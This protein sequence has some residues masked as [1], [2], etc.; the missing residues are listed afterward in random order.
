[1]LFIACRLFFSNLYLFFDVFNSNRPNE[2]PDMKPPV[3]SF[4]LSVFRL[5]FSTVH[6]TVFVTPNITKIGTVFSKHET[7]NLLIGVFCANI[8]V[9]LEDIFPS[10]ENIL[11][12]N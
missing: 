12:F 1:M 10:C 3:K 9:S 5:A 4:N 6:A 2:Q 11:E 8:N 7:P